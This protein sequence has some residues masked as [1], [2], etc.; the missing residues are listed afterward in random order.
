MKILSMYKNAPGTCDLVYHTAKHF[1]DEDEADAW[2][3]VPAGSLAA[4][5]ARE[6]VLSAGRQPPPTGEDV[7]GGWWWPPWVGHACRAHDE[8]Y[9][10]RYRGL[11]ALAGDPA[12]GGWE[13]AARGRRLTE[14]LGCRVIIEPVGEDYQ[15]ITAFF[16]PNFSGAS[17]L[18]HLAPALRAFAARRNCP[19]PVTAGVNAGESKR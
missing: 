2:D 18:R 3:E 1:L 6:Q 17:R 10:P 4:S 11:I 5:A 16:S 7:D 12:T 15:V 19:E 8:G 14:Y 13:D 9:A